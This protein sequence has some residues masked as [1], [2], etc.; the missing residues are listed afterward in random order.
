MSW[1]DL[2]NVNVFGLQSLKDIKN[3]PDILRGIRLDV[4]PA[5]VMEPRYQSRPEDLRKLEQLVGYMFYIESQCKPPALMLL[6]VGKTDTATTAGKI[7]E[8]P[9]ELL[10]EAIEKPVQPGVYGMFAITEKIK[11]WLTKELGL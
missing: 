2:C 8:I 5:M 7:D 6:K 4:T 10:Q 3:R 9:Q 11:A 1:E